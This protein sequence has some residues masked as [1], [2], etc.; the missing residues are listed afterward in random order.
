M[1][2]SALSLLAIHQ[3]QGCSNSLGAMPEAQFF[4]VPTFFMTMW[5]GGLGAYVYWH[6]HPKPNRGTMDD[7]E[8]D[9][10]LDETFT[11][12]LM[13]PSTR[14]TVMVRAAVEV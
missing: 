1:I 8:D 2:F 3:L 4:D 13:L 14:A 5:I 10:I 12:Q 9:T 6:L 11:L 7:K